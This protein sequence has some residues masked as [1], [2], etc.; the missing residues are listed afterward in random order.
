MYSPFKTD[1]LLLWITSNECCELKEILTYIPE[2][3]KTFWFTLFIVKAYWSINPLLALC[4][5]SECPL[6]LSCKPK[7]S[8]NRTSDSLNLPAFLPYFERDLIQK[9]AELLRSLFADPPVQL[10]AVWVMHMVRLKT[11]S[12]LCFYPLALNHTHRPQWIS[13]D[14]TS[15]N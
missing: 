12:T 14:L 11:R 13:H 5:K 1:L 9:S 10:G 7:H 6:E 8:E 15:V 3:M 2:Q 4:T